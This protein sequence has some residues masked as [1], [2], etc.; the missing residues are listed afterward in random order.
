MM[1]AT[2]AFGFPNPLFSKMETNTCADLCFLLKTEHR[3]LKTH[4]LEIHFGIEP[5]RPWLGA[6]DY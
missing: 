3:N 2:R 6:A 4:L 1:G 5:T